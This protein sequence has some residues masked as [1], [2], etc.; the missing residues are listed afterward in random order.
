MHVVA[1]FVEWALPPMV[2][3]SL[4]RLGRD[5]VEFGASGGLGPSADHGLVKATCSSAAAPKAPCCFTHLAIV[6]FGRAHLDTAFPA[7]ILLLGGSQQ[8]TPVSGV[9]LL[10]RPLSYVALRLFSQLGDV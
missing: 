4:P 3:P 10:V 7:I 6:C 2:P 5:W 8:R 9:L 1:A